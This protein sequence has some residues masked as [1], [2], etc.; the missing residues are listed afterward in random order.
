MLIEILEELWSK[1]WVR[2]TTVLAIVGLTV[3]LIFNLLNRKDYRNYGPFTTPFSRDKSFSQMQGNAVYSFNG[4]AFYKLDLSNNQTTVLHTVGRLPAPKQVAWAGDQG[5]LLN[6]SDSL[7]D[8]VV[9]EALARRGEEVSEATKLYTWYLDFKTGELRFVSQFPARKNLS[10]YSGEQGGIY[11]LPDRQAFESAFP[12]IP[13]GISRFS[14]NYYDIATNSDR[15]IAKDLNTV[16]VVEAFLC[17]NQAVCVMTIP[18]RETTKTSVR[19]YSKTGQVQ[20]YLENYNGRVFNSNS[21]DSVITAPN[22]AAEEVDQEGVEGG[23]AKTQALLYN[24]VTK[25]EYKLGFEVGSSSLLTNFD[26]RNFYV[27]DTNQFAEPNKPSRYYRVGV[28]SG[29][30]KPSTKLASIT[31]QDVTDSETGVYLNYA[32]YGSGGRTLL[33]PISGNLVLFGEVD[34]TKD[35][36]V[37]KPE[38]AKKLVAGCQQSGQP[39]VQYFDSAKQFRILISKT[40]TWQTDSA[41]FSACVAEKAA[42]AMM[43]Y[44]YQIALTDPVNGRLVSD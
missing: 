25:K 35:I 18:P 27:F 42:A 44:N 34:K 32:S 9:E 20:T 40:A 7:Y 3:L 24:L 4:L 33:A 39:E 22:V 16:D 21:L 6:F 11:Y 15:V 28:L 41:N 12:D 17:P 29:S 38:D 1:R 26:D 5:A 37:I 13:S 19:A 31:R 43:G 23:A 30:G 2:V 14:L 36:G 10:V 8:T